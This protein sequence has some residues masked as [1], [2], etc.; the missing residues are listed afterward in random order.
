MREKR[1]DT[2]VKTENVKQSM[3][4]EDK[5]FAVLFLLG[6]S[7]QVAVDYKRLEQLGAHF[8]IKVEDAHD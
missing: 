5:F 4:T 7:E 6:P 1:K 8:G 3:E 2:I